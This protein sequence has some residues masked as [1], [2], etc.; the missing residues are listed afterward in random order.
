MISRAALANPVKGLARPEKPSPD[1]APEPVRMVRVSYDLVR[2]EMG[3]LNG[4]RGCVN[5][6]GKRSVVNTFQFLSEKI[7]SS[8]DHPRKE[9]GILRRI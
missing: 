8:T 7:G 1:N 4:M 9:L 5:N 6:R 2:G 3:L